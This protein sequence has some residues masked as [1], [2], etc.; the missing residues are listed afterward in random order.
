MNAGMD[1]VSFKMDLETLTGLEKDALHIYAAVL[2]QL[3][4]ALIT[5]RTLGSWIPVVV[6][7]AAAIVNEWVDLSFSTWP[8]RGWQ[9]RESIHDVV[10][11]LLLPLLLLGLVRLIPRLFGLPPP[12]NERAPGD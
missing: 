3:A 1:W 7:T 11:T 9:Y 4:A 10:N 5:R 2:L 12:P 8:D 6:V